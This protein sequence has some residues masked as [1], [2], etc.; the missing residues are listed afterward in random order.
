MTSRGMVRILLNANGRLERLDALPSR[1]LSETPAGRALAG[2]P[3]LLLNGLGW[4]ALLAGSVGLLYLA[5]EP[6]VRKHWPDALISW[7]RVVGGRFRDPL[8]TSHVLVGISTGLVF[9][10]LAGVTVWA[11]N[12]LT[13]RP[14][15]TIGVNGARFLFGNLLVWLRF[16]AFGAV[17]YILV[18]LRSVVRRTWLADIL[19]VVLLWLPSVSSPASIPVAVLLLAGYVWVLRRFGL[20]ALVA[21]A[22]ANGAVEDQPLAAASWYA[23][24]SLT[25]PLVIAA[26]A[27]WSLYVILTSRPGTASRPVSEYPM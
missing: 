1:A 7:L 21:M 6:F 13:S 12:D 18:L 22:F 26:A 15:V 10:L 25:T 27:A 14:A 4:A 23:A 9:A 8:A 2:Q 24:L 17:G 11:T 20:L 5:V 3:Y 16:S 19:F